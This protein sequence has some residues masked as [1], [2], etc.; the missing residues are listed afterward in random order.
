MKG[1]SVYPNNMNVCYCSVPK[2]CPT[3]CDPMDYSTP[4]FPVLHYLPEFTQVHVI[5]SVISSKHLI[6]CFPSLLLPSIFPSIRVFSNES[7][8][9]IRWPKHWSFSF[10]ISP[11]NEYSGLISHRINWFDLLVV[12]GNLKSLLQHHSSKAS[13]LR[14]SAFFMVQLSEPYMTTGKTIALTIR[15]VVGKMM[16]LPFNT[17]SRF[18]ID[19]FPRSRDILI[20]WLKSPSTV[21][22]E[23]KKRKSVTASIS[24]SALNV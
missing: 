1:T 22:L 17:L 11:S 3:L 4:G 12:Q 9:R 16:S 10:S 7:A 21:I 6:L 18:V 24:T 23:P 2:S 15:T 19:F 8:L 5:E 14:H 20:S 13:T